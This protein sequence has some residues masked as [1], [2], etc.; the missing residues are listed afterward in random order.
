MTGVVDL[1]RTGV[2]Q[3]PSEAWKFM[4]DWSRNWNFMTA[5]RHGAGPSAL[6]GEL[7]N[8]LLES[9]HFHGILEESSVVEPGNSSGLSASLRQERSSFW[10]I[11]LLLHVASRRL[12]HF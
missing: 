11:S 3:S 5:C 2:D 7:W 12:L 9:H 10:P 1:A 6:P 4:L 8:D